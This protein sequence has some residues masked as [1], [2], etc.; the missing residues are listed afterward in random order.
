MTLDKSVDDAQRTL[1]STVCCTNTTLFGSAIGKFQKMLVFSLTFPFSTLIFS[2]QSTGP[3]Y[4]FYLFRSCF[5]RSTE[6]R[7]HCSKKNMGARRERPTPTRS[8]SWSSYPMRRSAPVLS[9]LACPRMATP[10]CCII[11][12]LD[13][14]AVSCAKS[15][16]RMVDAAPATLA[17]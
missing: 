13:N 12:N 3:F 5:F 10:A 2:L 6:N 1:P 17:E 16:S 15:A 4:D 14:S 9:P 8:K 11:W 7:L